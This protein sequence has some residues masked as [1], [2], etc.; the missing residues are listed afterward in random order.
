MLQ[1]LVHP[2]LGDVRTASFFH[3]GTNFLASYPLLCIGR[4]II[5]LKTECVVFY[6][7][8]TIFYS[9]KSDFI[10]MCYYIA[11]FLYRTSQLI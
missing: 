6:L 7:T 5:A 9:V 10:I 4:L 8:L 1:Y 11:S 3:I 2:I